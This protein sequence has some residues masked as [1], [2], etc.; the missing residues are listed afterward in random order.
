M[1]ALSRLLLSINRSAELTSIRALFIFSA[2]GVT[3]DLLCCVLGDIFLYIEGGLGMP[4]TEAK[5]NTAFPTL[6]CTCTSHI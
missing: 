6:C 3:A 5:W 1:V 2:V 4:E